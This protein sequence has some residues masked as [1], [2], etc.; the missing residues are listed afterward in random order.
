VTL[1]FALCM[2]FAGGIYPALLASA[3][4]LMAF[5]GYAKFRRDRVTTTFEKQFA[6]ALGLV[7]RSLR[8]GQPMLAGFRICADQSPEPVRHVFTEICQQQ[9]LGLGLEES[10]RRIGEKYSSDD[11]QLFVTAVVIQMRSGGNLADLMD[12]LAYIIR[13][14]MRLGR[15]VKVLTAQ[16]Q[17]SKRILIGLPFA[18][19]VV[20]N[21]LNPDY[22]EPLYTTPVGRMLLL[23]G[24]G[25]ML[26]GMYVMRRLAVL[27]Y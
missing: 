4:V 27:R 20:I 1:V 7:A 9:T 3:A 2:L 6:E 13:E 11:V 25:S 22:M 26:L 21:L 16:T 5:S 10:L 19:F 15:R 23:V 14:R 24:A 12:R 18:V 17:M 8:A